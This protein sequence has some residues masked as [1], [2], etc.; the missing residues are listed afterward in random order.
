MSV[1]RTKNS[2][3][4]MNLCYVGINRYPDL[5]E[6][7]SLSQFVLILG[8]FWTFLGPKKVVEKCLRGTSGPKT[9]SQ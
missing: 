1:L 4:I 3:S 2:M 6:E 7:A 5:P 8:L 9:Q